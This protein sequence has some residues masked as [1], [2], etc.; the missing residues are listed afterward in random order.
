METNMHLHMFIN[1]ACENH[2]VKI[3]YAFDG[4][5]QWKKPQVGHKQMLFLFLKKEDVKYYVC[6]CVKSQSIE[7]MYKKSK[8]YKSY[9]IV[10]EP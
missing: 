2:G 10:N 1:N 6:I 7:S 4:T 3:C 9:P 8:F 5:S